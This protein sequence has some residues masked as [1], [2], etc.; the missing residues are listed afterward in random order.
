MSKLYRKL[1]LAV[2]VSAGLAAAGAAQAQTAP[3]TFTRRIA[4]GI[5][6]VEQ[7]AN[8]TVY[9]N[10]SDLELV[11]DPTQNGNAQVVGLR[12]TNVTLPAGAYVTNAYIQF[13]TDEQTYGTS[14]LLIK[15]QA[16]D[17][18][19][20]FTTATADVSGRTTT[21]AAVTWA[22]G[23][24]TTEGQASTG[25]A[26]P[27]LKDV[28]Q[29]I[30]GR[31]GWL[32]GNALVFTITG[33]GTKTAEAY[34]GSA[35]QAPQLVVEYFVPTIR[36]ASV[37]VATGT[38]DAEEAASGSIDLTS[39]DLELVDDPG[40]NGNNQT[41]GLRF[42]GLNIPA[43][44]TITRAYVQFSVDE[45][46]HTAATNLLIKAQAADNAATFT[47]ASRNLSSRPLTTAGVSWALAIWTTAN[48]A[49]T[50]QATPDLKAVVQ[51][52]I[53]RTGW[54]SGNA[55]AL[56]VTGTGR[57]N[58]HAYNG[59]PTRAPQLVVEY[60]TPGPAVGAFPV[61]RGATWKFHD[62]G[63]DLGTAW[64][65]PAYNDATWSYGP[66][67]LGYGDPVTTTLGFGPNSAAK[68]PTYYLRH[69][70]EVAN[71][72]LYDTLTF[73]MRRD[74]G[75]VVYLNGVEQFRTNMPS[76]TISYSTYASGTVD[77]ANETA[78]FTFKVPSR[79]LLTGANVLAVELHQDRASSS[80]VTFD[81]EMSGR[82]IPVKNDTPVLTAGSAWKYLD[83]GSNQGTAWK[84]PAFNDATWTSGS[85]V[86][87]YGNGDETTRVSFGPDAT[88]KH[89]TTYFRKTFAVA[90]T[91]GFKGLELALT[92]DDAAVVYLN[93]TEVLRS[94][95]A[96]GALNYQSTALTAVEG[97]DETTPIIAYIDKRLLAQGT[98]TLAV[99][100]HKFS[101]SDSDL[102]FDAA[103]RL[104][105]AP[106]VTTPV[107]AIVNCD[108]RTSTTIG[109]FTSVRPTA[110]TQGMVFPSA[111]HAFQE[112]A[113]SGVTRYSG[114][115]QTLPGNHDFTGYIARGGSSKLGYLSINHENDPGGVSM[116]NLRLNETT[117]TWA[118]DSVRKVDFGPL[119]KTT[120][121]CSGGLTPWGTIIT[122]EETVNTGD[123][124]G[125]GYQDV[126]WQVEINPVTGRI[127]DHTGDGRPDKLW[128]MG[129][130]S[131]ENIAISRDS[132][133]IYECED[134]G[135]SCVYKFVADQKTKLYAGSLYVL[136][137]DNA[138]STTGTWIRVPNATPADRNNVYTV[139]T[140]LGGTNWNQ[141]EDIEFGPDGKM[142]FTSKGSGTIWRFKDNGGTV[143]DIEAWVTN[144]NYP[145]THAGG[146]QNESWGTGIDNLT[147]DGEGNLW[148]LQDGGRN[149][150]WVIRP[151]HTPANPHVELFMTTPAGS[152]P[153]GLT[154]SPDFR[155]GF[156][157]FQHANSGNTLT[158]TDAAGN[159]VRFNAN[160]T[161]VF[162]R[163]EYLGASAVLPAF[164][165]GADRTLCAGDSVRLR[166]YT[167]RD[168]VVRFR[169]PG[170]ISA[171]DS[172]LTVRTSGTYYATAT[173]NAGRTYTD[174]VRVTVA[175]PLVA[176]LGPDQSLCATCSLTLTPGAGFASYLWSD[177]STGSS[178]TATATGTYFVRV[179]NAS[180]CAATDTIRL[181]APNTVW[182]GQ[183]STDWFA[184]GNWSGGVP[185]ATLDAYVGA[186]A[187]RYPALSTGTATARS[188]TLASGA[189][190]NVSGGM[191]D[192]KG[193]FA[194]NGTLTNTG[195]MLRLSGTTAQTIGGSAA[196]TFFDLSVGGPGATL[197]GSV[198]V[199]RGLLLNGNLNTAGQP[200]T[201]LSNATGTAMVVN[202]GGV[203]TGQA[204]VQRYIAPSQ[205]AGLGYRHYSAP[206]SGSS[207]G[208]M[209]TAGFAPVVNPAYNTSA[210][211]NMVT[212]FPNVFGYDQDR[213]A[214]VTSNMPAFDKGW[215]SPAA[216][217][218]L[219]TPGRGYTVNIAAS[220]TVSFTGLLTNGDLAPLS[221]ARNTGSTA[222]DAGWH[223]VGNP[224]PA[225]LDYGQVA[226]VDRANLDA[227]IYVF[228]SSSQYSGSYRTVLPG[229]TGDGLLAS[230]QGFF[231]R[232]SMPGVAGA[233][234]F[235]NS[236]RVTDFTTPTTFRRGTA[237]T[238]PLVQLALQGSTGPADV[239]TVH[240]AA[241]A[242]LGL[243]AAYDAVKLTNPS[244]LNLAAPAPAG[245][246]LSIVGLPA[247]TASTV[248]PLSVGVPT[249]G[250]YTLAAAQ[251]LN[252]PAPLD[253]FLTDAATGQTVN[254]RQQAAYSFAVTSAQ[255]AALITGRFTLHFAQRTVTAATAALTGTEVALYPNPAHAAFTVLV[256][257]VAGA[258]AVQADLL[259]ALGQ[260]VRHQ[261]VPTLATGARF[262]VETA[263]LAKGIYTLRLRVAAA[264]LTKRV[265]IQ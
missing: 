24:W 132:V 92:R 249:A 184:A 148:S 169:G 130:M 167:G 138:T 104:L 60:F 210:T 229:V 204:S 244:G 89:L 137:R 257:A 264:T 250:T 84:V 216:L 43:T 239:L 56:L 194:N 151:D 195:G 103:L 175:A 254:L 111:T 185:T 146:T 188:L 29:E 214:S 3:Q 93:G 141:L 67:V 128:A 100:V 2:A 36:T 212:S 160:T 117:M 133:T 136:K 189:A 152:E 48:A 28:V 139:A 153:T 164:E 76:G 82:L 260:V 181:V 75:A 237:T 258:T 156:L 232:T 44:A 165:L 19:P 166:A 161:L 202:N 114:T 154:F 219:M 102:R 17:N 46:Q 99:E 42:A 107:T 190:L 10:S 18:A 8:G 47:S 259:N 22:P 155:Y 251:L 183:V 218:D 177:G 246:A 233:L 238:K 147:F 53:G 178:L 90:D 38:D 63:Q 180:G 207:V 158:Q 163:K 157:S 265:V 65:T 209:A 198:A 191:L 50:A 64:T 168:A 211:P 149:H 162:A 105:V 62:Q 227:A 129:R 200:F 11:D 242:T 30:I 39:S 23:D 247:L 226:A 33:S 14:S 108:P 122:S 187:P 213:L 71:A 170:A 40:D 123:A 97:A 1:L 215:V 119:V 45:T 134:G 57:R 221:L 88:N 79:Q 70:F 159:A 81:L 142:Y 140:A 150:L 230:G 87:G 193:N 25:Q 31:T 5:D 61:P 35:A 263:G 41:V 243:D 253:V 95:L 115:N 235:R 78:Y 248:V 26:T 225:P 131:H 16:A 37:R 201:L 127:V 121:N 20:T 32:S 27:N 126:G 186:G 203:V 245:P 21:A 54:Q 205:N 208:G 120:R 112:L 106:Q 52:V 59:Q 51:E 118:V 222:A 236:Q 252:L 223:L 12:F 73:Q 176:S 256:P 4:A 116:L 255:A 109:C 145:I 94:N 6:D 196:S 101:A 49:G 80:D 9:T 173:T 171:T 34:E 58:A 228:E 69:N 68:Y 261:T 143:S 220:Q 86:L 197:A 91:S 98:N 110:Q 83:N 7:A 85:A 77:G 206:V 124:N 234:T 66:A 241:Q 199:Q 135:S 224:Y 240:E 217:S 192:L 13:T 96:P 74:D 72:A 15:G 182:T 172:V 231:V 55:L 174:S 125:D 179:T 113:K 262:T 144:R